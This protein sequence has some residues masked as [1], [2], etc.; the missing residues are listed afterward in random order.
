L[1]RKNNIVGR[2]DSSRRPCA[3]GVT[4]AQTQV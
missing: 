3:G 1:G 2:A 4:R